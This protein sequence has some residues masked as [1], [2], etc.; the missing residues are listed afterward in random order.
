M[1][2]EAQGPIGM[3]QVFTN[4]LKYPGDPDGGPEEVINCRCTLVPEVEV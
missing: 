4:G 1:A 2:A 3:A